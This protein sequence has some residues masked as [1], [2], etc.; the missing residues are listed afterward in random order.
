MRYVRLVLVCECHGE[1]CCVDSDPERVDDGYVCL[2]CGAESAWVRE[3][4]LTPGSRAWRVVPD[5]L[6]PVD[7]ASGVRGRFG[8]WMVAAGAFSEV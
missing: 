3:R 2:T 7:D 4:I 1:V 6:G 5:D 8:H